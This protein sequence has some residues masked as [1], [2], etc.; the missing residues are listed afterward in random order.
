MFVLSA[1][2]L[3]QPKLEID[4]YY[5]HLPNLVSCYEKGVIETI[6]GDNYLS[7]NTPLPYILT[8]VPHYI[9][10]LKP[11]IYSARIFNAIIAYLTIFIFYL[12]LK[13]NGDSNFLLEKTLL[14]LFYPYFLKPAFTYYMAVYGVLFFLA[15]LFYFDKYRSNWLLVG[16]MLG[17]AVMSQQFYLI[18]FLPFG[19]YLLNEEK[20]EYSIAALKKTILL[21]IPVI[22][23][24]LPLAIGWGGL[25]HKNF[26]FHE[27]RFQTTHITSILVTIGM[28]FMPYLIIRA[29][30]FKIKTVIILLIPAIL[31][32]LFA[33]PVIILRGGEG[34]ITGMSFRAI[35]FTG[36]IIPILP[37]LVKTTIVSLGLLLLVDLY[38]I[39][40]SDYEKLLFYIIC[41]FI[42]GFTFN[43]ILAERH[44]LPLIATILLF[45][46][47]KIQNRVFI[48][49]WLGFQIVIGLVYYYYYLYIKAIY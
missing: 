26:R 1:I 40:K 23:L 32:V 14:F 24:F 49:L 41:S 28:V 46:L 48:R 22:I 5:N 45:I 25:T 43:T 18:A 4:E 27:I 16:I 10:N 19:L 7:A 12:L 42:I 20:Y 30:T 38:T 2:A 39:M 35:D 34:A 33:Y 44:L 6:F 15:A 47:P 17:S 9:I 8:Y 11:N 29:K 36:K 37:F 3:L 31:L 13:R 21:I